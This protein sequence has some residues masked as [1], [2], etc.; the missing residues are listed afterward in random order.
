MPIQC[1]DFQGNHKYTDF[2]HKNDKVRIVH[3]V[4]QDETLEDMGSRVPR[5][6]VALENKQAEFQSHII[7]VEGMINSH[8]FTILIDSGAIHSYIDPRM[9]E[10]LHLSRTKHEKYWLV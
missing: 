9:V 10:S 2:P 7:E 6:Y 5:I 1:W 4:Q 8:I 3:N